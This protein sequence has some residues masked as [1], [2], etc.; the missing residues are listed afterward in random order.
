MFRLL[1]V[2][3]FCFSVLNAYENFTIDSEKNITSVLA[4]SEKIYVGTTDGLQIYKGDSLILME[5]LFEGNHIYEIKK[6]SSEI[7]VLFYSSADNLNY[8]YNISLSKLSPL[9]NI[10]SSETFLPLSMTNFIVYDNRENVLLS[11]NTE[12]SK[13]DF[14]SDKNAGFGTYEP[15]ALSDAYVDKPSSVCGVENFYFILSPNFRRISYVN[16]GELSTYSRCDGDIC[17]Y[18]IDEASYYPWFAA[19]LIRDNS[20]LK[21]TNVASFYFS[22]DNLIFYGDFAELKKII[23]NDNF[24]VD[25]F[26]YDDGFFIAEKN[27]ILFLKR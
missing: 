20:K 16:D 3:L 15:V 11:F 19:S 24:I 4:D 12:T 2:L 23:E 1:V 8:I 27:R 18:S 9:E 25:F 14:L 26:P 5:N 6:Y 10:S 22:S 17:T 7:F 21:C 13:I